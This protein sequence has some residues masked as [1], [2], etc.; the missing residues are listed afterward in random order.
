MLKF[1]AVS[2]V[3]VQYL[4]LVRIIYLVPNRYNTCTGT[5]TGIGQYK[6]NNPIYH[7]WGY[8]IIRCCEEQKKNNNYLFIYIIILQYY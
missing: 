4:Y 8:N 6:P 2:F 7:V 1:D 5:G 3:Q